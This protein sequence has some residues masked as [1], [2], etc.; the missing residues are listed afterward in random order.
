MKDGGCSI[1]VIMCLSASNCSKENVLCGQAHC[2]IRILVCFL[3][4]SQLCQN[5]FILILLHCCAIWT[6]PPKIKKKHNEQGFKFGLVFMS[7]FNFLV[8]TVFSCTLT[9]VSSYDHTQRSRFHPYM[10]FWKMHSA[11][12]LCR[13]LAQISLWR[14]SCSGMRILGT[15]LAQTLFMLISSHTIFHPVS[16]SM[17]TASIIIWTLCWQSFETNGLIFLTVLV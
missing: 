16:L 15:I 4:L 1:V 9:V 11:S 17:F 8:M 10:V 2:F 3:W 12:I 14:S 13:M 6:F 5:C 7:S